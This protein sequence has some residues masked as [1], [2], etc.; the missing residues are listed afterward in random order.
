M[1]GWEEVPCPW[2]DAP[3]GNLHVALVAMKNPPPWPP[4]LKKFGDR[5]NS[6]H[7]LEP[8]IRCKVCDQWQIGKFDGPGHVLFDLQSIIEARQENNSEELPRGP[9]PMVRCRARMFDHEGQWSLH[10]LPAECPAYG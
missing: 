4:D 6:W 9:M 8:E 1:A 5:R 2:C 3:P 10:R 7:G